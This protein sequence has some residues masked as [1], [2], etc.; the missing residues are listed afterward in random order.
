MRGRLHMVGVG[1]AT[2]AATVLDVLTV[3]IVECPGE[4]L[5]R[6]REGLDRAMA[7]AARAA[8]QAAPAAEAGGQFDRAT[9]GL[10]PHQI[11]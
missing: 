1:P 11:G 2:P 5:K 9:W 7:T 10:L 6:W 4:P 3:V 8:H